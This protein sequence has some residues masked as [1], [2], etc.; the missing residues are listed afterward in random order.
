MYFGLIESQVIILQRLVKPLYVNNT[1]YSS[2]I[3]EYC[4]TTGLSFKFHKRKCC[5]FCG[6][7]WDQSKKLL[8]SEKCR[9][10]IQDGRFVQTVSNISQ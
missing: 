2:I 5:C 6:N 3:F 4:I 8:T 7:F 9:S 1:D 10:D